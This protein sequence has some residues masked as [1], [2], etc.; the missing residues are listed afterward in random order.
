MTTDEK[1]RMALQLDRLGVDVIEAGFP[2]S[3]DGDFHSV[4]LV[5]REICRPVWC[6]RD[7]I[8]CRMTYR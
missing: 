7:Q 5:A 4:Q 3:S 8:E 2:V 1:L 6:S